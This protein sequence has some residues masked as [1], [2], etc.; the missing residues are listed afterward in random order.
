[1]VWRLLLLH[2]PVLGGLR[3]VHIPSDPGLRGGAP[4]PCGGGDRYYWYEGSSTWNSFPADERSAD[5]SQHIP[6]YETVLELPTADIA[7]ADY[8]AISGVNCIY[9]ETVENADGI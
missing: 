5:L 4:R 7:M 6:T 3:L 9:V 2:G 8:R 1:M